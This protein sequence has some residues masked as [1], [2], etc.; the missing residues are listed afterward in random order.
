MVQL[1]LFQPRTDWRAPDLTKLP[2]WK[3]A[4]R[5]A[6]DIETHDPDLKKTGIGVRRK[7][8]MI[9]VSFAIE[10][11]DTTDLSMVPAFYLP[12]GHEGGDNLDRE[13]VLRYLRDQAAHFR[14]DIVGANLGYDLDY[15][16][17][18]DVR[19]E[20]RFIRDVQIAEPLLDENQFS[21]SLQNIA[22]RNGFEGKDHS[23]LEV[24]AMMFGIE[25]VK[26]ELWKLPARHVGPYAE[27]DARLPLRLIQA[28][29]RR[30]MAEDEA[31]QRGA[32]LWDLYDLESRLIWPLI[33]M[34]R[35]GVKID[36]DQLDRV[37]ARALREEEDALGEVSRLSGVRV[38]I[39]DINRPTVAGKAI[40]VATGANL[41][42]TGK[43]NQPSL[44]ASILQTIKHPIIELYLKAKRFNK[45][46]TTFVASIREHQVNGR[47]HCTFNQL[48]R[49]NDEGDSSGTVSGR[50]SSTD[51]NLQQQPAR[52]PDIGPF[53][54]AIYVADDGGKWASWDYSQQ[55]P[56]W[57]TH[58]AEVSNCVGARAAADR[59]RAD[60]TIDNHT[61]MRDM[62]GWEGKDGRS[63][64]KNIFLGLCYSMGGAKLCRSIGKPTKWITTASGRSIEVA[65]D[66]GQA[67]LDQF[68]QKVPFIREIAM[69]AENAAKKKGYI[70]TVLG[71]RC[72]FPRA[73]GGRPGYDWTHKAF[74][75]LVQGSSADQTKKAMLLIE[76]AGLIHEDL[77]RSSVALQVHDELDGTVFEEPTIAHVSEIMRTAVP[78][79]VPHLVEPKVG[80]HWGECK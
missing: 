44:K 61:M 79:N 20:P 10:R 65:G 9:G 72:R 19:F 67:I 53:W 42:R 28:Q 55:E 2:S 49:E 13:T 54:R 1:P 69:R 80:K 22:Q 50:L 29:E 34:R 31:D 4:R 12:F 59:Y 40:E 36:F 68:D 73:E 26:A 46:R 33:K 60:P 30:L 27:V 52:D 74:N 16:A 43:N 11:D 66:E 38:T 24:A 6:I 37:E 23:H 70:R 63:R 75:R 8:R 48:K 56:R 77:S 41:P 7:G 62:I 32:R 15:L 64:A 57:I 14:G 47:V 78:C 35:R 25:D 71:R 76:E 5:V 21:Y 39:A 3:G 45:L 58:F 18:V 51:P 17:Q